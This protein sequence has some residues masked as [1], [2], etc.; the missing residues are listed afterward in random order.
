MS[1]SDMLL[2]Q[3]KHARRD[4]NSMRIEL[5]QPHRKTGLDTG[6][7]NDALREV[8]QQQRQQDRQLQHVLDTILQASTKKK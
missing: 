3:V 7:I 5:R 6:Y 4:V 1:S 8:N 2:R